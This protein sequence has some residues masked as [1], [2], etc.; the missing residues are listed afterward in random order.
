HRKE[1]TMNYF[2]QAIEFINDDSIFIFD[3]IHWSAE[4]KAAWNSIKAHPQVT[5]TIDLFFFGIVFFR[6]QLSKQD[7]IL[8]F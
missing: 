4:M 2:R 8:R 7:F 6:K 5:L 1:P 3:D